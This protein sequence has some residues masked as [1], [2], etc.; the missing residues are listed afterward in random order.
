MNVNEFIKLAKEKNINPIQITTTKS[1]NLDLDILNNRLKNFDISKS[2]DYSITAHYNNKDIK[3]NTNY[4]EQDIIDIIINKA[5]IIESNYK[6]IYIEDNR[7]TKDKIED[8]SFDIK[9]EQDEI[10]KSHTNNNDSHITDIEA[11]Y[12]I[13]NL[14][15]SI[16]NSYGLDISTNKNL[17]V[18]SSE[19]TSKEQD[20][21]SNIWN[22][23]YSTKK[24]INIKEIIQRTKE[25]S[26]CNLKK[27]CI[28]SGKYNVILSSV[29]MSKLLFNFISLLSKE[30]IRK[31]NSCLEGKLNKKIFGN[32]ITIIEYPNNK[33]YPGYNKFDNEGTETYKKTII[34]KGV[35]KTYLYNN[36]E[37]LLD[38]RKSTGN[39]YGV[40][41][42]ANIYINPGNKSEE[43]LINSIEEGL[44]IKE[45]Q[46]TGGT[47]IN[48]NNGDISV[49]IK[50]QIIKDGKK[51]NSFET[52]ILTT[53]IYE[54]LSNVVEVGNNLEFKTS[55]SASPSLY[56]KDMSISSN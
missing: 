3:V 32:N 15:K 24:D 53:N 20:N 50:G 14:E 10:L 7:K 45:F 54:L 49:Q 48:S 1:N 18:F 27:K 35:L 9:K 26:I 52:S 31:Q 34:D 38:N 43:D 37:A 11:Y 17:C 46:S 41:S 21:I 44:Y 13:L 16:N 28:E 56:V 5:N 29:F 12:T 6:E 22:T 4:L 47:V 40:I 23:T 51:T 39:A 55:I 25:E 2:I 33:E 36:K 8:I 42:A 30:N 19:V